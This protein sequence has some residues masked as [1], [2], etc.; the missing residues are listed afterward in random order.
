MSFRQF[1]GLQYAARNNIVSSKYNT[2]N[3]L[4]V[5]GDIGQPV[6]YINCLSDLS[7]N[8]TGDFS[9]NF[10]GYLT[11]NII[12]GSKGDLLYQSSANNTSFLNPGITPGYVLTSNGPSSVPTWQEVAMG[13]IPIADINL[14]AYT[15]AVGLIDISGNNLSYIFRDKTGLTFNALT[16][17]L[18]CP[19]FSGN[20]LG[21]ATTATNATNATNAT[22]AT[23]AINI[24]GGI[25]G[26][27]LYQTDA[28]STSFISSSQNNNYVLTWI[29]GLPNWAPPSSGQ[30]ITTGNNIYF[31]GI[32][33]H[34]GNVGINTNT[35]IAALDVSGSIVTSQDC[36]INSVT[37]GLG[38]GNISS[39][40]ALGQSALHGN[41][42]GSQNT[43]IGQSALYGNTTGSQNTAV[44]Q[45]A[46]Q[47]NTGSQNTAVGTYSLYTN[48]SGFQ[49][50]ALG[51][52]SLYHNNK[53]NYNTGLGQAALYNVDGSYNT[54]VGYNSG[55][56]DFSGNYNTY[57]GANASQGD[58]NI[59]TYSTAIGANAQIDASNQI[60]L[61]GQNA[62]GNYPN[63]LVPG[64]MSITN[65]N[66]STSNYTQLLV[67]QSI[68]VVPSYDYIEI[69][70]LS[71]NL[72]GN[73]YSYW[74]FNK[75]SEFGYVKKNQP[76]WS[77]GATPG[78]TPSGTN[79]YIDQSGNFN[80]NGVI[81][82]NGSSGTSGYV[83]TSQG[84][85][86]PI[87]SI[88]GN[89]AWT[90]SGNN[91]YYNTGNVGIG[92]SNPTSTLDVSGNFVTSS[93]VINNNGGYTASIPGYLEVYGTS[94]TLY[95]NS[96][97]TGSYHNLLLRSTKT[98]T[99]PTNPSPYSMALGV[100]ASGGFGYITCAGN[101]TTQ[102]LYLNPRGGDIQMGNTGMSN[103]S[104]L[105]VF[106]TVSATSFNATSDYRIKENVKL[107]DIASFNI[108][109]LKPVTYINKKTSRQ[110]IGL[111]AHELQE[112][113]P[114]L[115][116]GQKDGED[117]QSV[118]YIGLIG[119]LIKEIQELK[120]V[121]ST[122]SKSGNKI[123]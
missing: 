70:D 51:E 105:M 53:G 39:N 49:N 59:Y 46:L 104:N 47:S 34:G 2:N 95:T 84:S 87:W 118:N 98:P 90:G 96:P 45:T 117:M 33:T 32:N 38:A 3:N 15:Y 99:N 37:I 75:I 27:I 97:D 114:F 43:A 119:I 61:G 21:N 44:G 76:L 25:A 7:G 48:T 5:T 9:G 8:F 1:G 28:N 103:I 6:S 50:T 80:T 71:Q 113:Y 101:S 93:A 102:P 74:F 86:P 23:N 4:Q 111:I 31:N 78:V 55:V 52:I 81:R 54:A 10:S 64:T 107:L 41:T 14:N 58:S 108:D 94:N 122:F 120:K 65:K 100:D 123:D 19:D 83:L 63:V 72:T 106:G 12:G 68:N 82:L 13:S 17:T 121:C 110:D 79:W 73:A 69:A 57:L 60:M 36:S 22:S 92:K 115:V 20:L 109:K 18:N 16:N 35:P 29:N 112:E 40:T 30:W 42:T 116:T 91:I 26:N 85:S 56:L 77:I 89:S 88:P 11:G 62:S 67:G 24:Y 66:A